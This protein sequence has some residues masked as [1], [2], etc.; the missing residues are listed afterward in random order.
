MAY[1]SNFHVLLVNFL[2]FLNRN[3]N[4]NLFILLFINKN[5]SKLLSLFLKKTL[6]STDQEQKMTKK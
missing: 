1:L 5:K 6:L 2:I 3:K 4:I